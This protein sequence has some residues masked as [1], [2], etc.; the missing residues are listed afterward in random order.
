M[1]IKLERSNT[2]NIDDIARTGANNLV[3]DGAYFI[4][5]TAGVANKS[6]ATEEIAGVN[7][8]QGVFDADNEGIAL[9]PVKIDPAFRGNTYIAAISGGAVT[10]LVESQYFDLLTT[11][12]DTIDGTTVSTTTGQVQLVRFITATSGEFKIV[13]K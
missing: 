7:Y 2:A 10:K 1:S 4:T 12:G 8:T 11:A 13:N 6:A 5:I 3:L 9:T